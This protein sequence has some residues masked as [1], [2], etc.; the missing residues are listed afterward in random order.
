MEANTNSAEQST[1]SEI[2][3][4][5]TKAEPVTIQN[6]QVPATK[7]DLPNIKIKIENYLNKIKENLIDNAKNTIEIGNLL[8]SAKSIFKHK[9]GE[10][11]KWIE[12]N[13]PF[14]YTMAT[15]FIKCAERFKDVATAQYLTQS[16]MFELLSLSKEET[17]EFIEEK[18]EKNIVEMSVKKLRKEIKSWK[19]KRKTTEQ[20]LKSEQIE[21]INNDDNVINQEPD[22]IE[23]NAPSDSNI[24]SPDVIE[25]EEQTCHKSQSI[26]EPQQNLDENEYKTTKKEDGENEIENKIEQFF[27]ISDSLANRKNLLETMIK[28]VKKN[29]NHNQLDVIIQNLTT[30]ISKLQTINKKE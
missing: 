24:V 13:F 3:T 16:Q 15:R 11:I 6:N 7:I 29:P 8:T 9:H 19:S 1:T 14:D 17:K 25:I 27:V 2:T 22:E 30:I 20:P 4:A 21:K 23:Q 18:K 28:F 26:S 12:N 5:L 10:W